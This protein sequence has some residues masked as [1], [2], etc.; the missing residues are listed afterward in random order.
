MVNFRCFC[1]LTLHTLCLRHFQENNIFLSLSAHLEKELFNQ[2]WD[3]SNHVE[4]FCQRYYLDTR[5]TIYPLYWANISLFRLQIPPNTH[6]LNSNFTHNFQ[7]SLCADVRMFQHEYPLLLRIRCTGPLSLL[8]DGR[9]SY[10]GLLCN[11]TSFRD[12]WLG[13]LQ[14]DLMRVL[15]IDGFRRKLKSIHTLM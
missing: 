13:S 5:C 11:N 6:L 1:V 9:Q 7:E 15:L 12:D 4:G 2:A 14:I 10:M 8:Q 3:F